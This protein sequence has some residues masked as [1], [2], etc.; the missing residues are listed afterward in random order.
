MK[1][2]MFSLGLLLLGILLSISLG[3]LLLLLN[4]DTGNFYGVGMGIV[5][6]LVVLTFVGYLLYDLYS[7]AVP[8][9]KGH[10]QERT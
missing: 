7:A 4:S 2:P 5:L 8:S 6:T 1:S 10:R 9:K 3:S